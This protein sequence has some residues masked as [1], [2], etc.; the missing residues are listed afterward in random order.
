M[1]TII[2]CFTWSSYLTEFTAFLPD[3]QFFCSAAFFFAS[4]SSFFFLFLSFFLK[5]PRSRKLCCAASI[6]SSSLWVLDLRF[7]IVP[8]RFVDRVVSLSS[9]PRAPLP[10]LI[11]EEISARF[12]VM[13]AAL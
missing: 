11:R 5:K 10:L 8:L 9:L 1:Q 6:F 2:P 4:S 7:F 3:R 13:I 12:P